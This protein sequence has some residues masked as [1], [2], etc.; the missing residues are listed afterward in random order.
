MDLIEL[1]SWESEVR[2][3][4]NLEISVCENIKWVLRISSRVTGFHNY[5]FQTTLFGG[6]HKKIIDPRNQTQ[7]W[8]FTKTL[9]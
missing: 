2:S 8:S 4:G 5:L 9:Q 1:N 7:L 6:V 3:L